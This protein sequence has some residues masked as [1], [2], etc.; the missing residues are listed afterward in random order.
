[1][2][3]P[4]ET[5]DKVAQVAGVGVKSVDP[6]E[7]AP[8]AHGPA[9]LGYFAVMEKDLTALEVPLACDTTDGY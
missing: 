7:V 2:D 8:S 5:V 9:P 1:V 6:M 3:V 4:P